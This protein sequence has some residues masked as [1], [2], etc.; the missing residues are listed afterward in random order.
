M[1]STDRFPEKEK[2]AYVAAVAPL[3]VVPDRANAAEAGNL[4][5]VDLR[6]GELARRAAE[7]GIRDG[8]AEAETL[9]SAVALA[10]EQV[11]ELQRLRTAYGR[12]RG[13]ECAKGILMERHRVSERSAYQLLH[14]QARNSNLPLSEV[15]QA[16]VESHLLLQRPELPDS[17]RV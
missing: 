12:L 5:L 2:V 10:L 16:V 17:T 4:V 11:L 13:V 1:R 14:R 7:I 15:A 3:S 8:L 9:E 6:D